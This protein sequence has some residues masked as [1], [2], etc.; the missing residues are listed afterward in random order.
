[1]TLRQPLILGSASPR[2]KYL[3]EQLGL[4]FTVRVSHVEEVLPT[5]YP[6]A[7]AAGYLAVLKADACAHFLDTGAAVLTADTVVVHEGQLLGKPA[8]RADALQGLR[9]LQNATHTVYTGVVLQYLDKFGAPQRLTHIDESTVHI[10]ACSE[11]ELAH[12]VDHNEVLD[13]AGGYG[14]QDWFGW[15]KVERIDGSY[16][17]VM[18]LPTAAVWKMLRQAELRGSY[19]DA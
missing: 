15:T 1:M 3:L 19:A 4:D 6:V 17:N 16:S 7:K 18:G 9:R 14:I 8:H 2:R 12:Y 5:G 10:A 13:K 11:A